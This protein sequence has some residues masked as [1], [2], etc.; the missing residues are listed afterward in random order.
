[1]EAAG[2]TAF[3]QVADQYALGSP[4]GPTLKFDGAPVVAGDR[5]AWAPLGAEKTASGY[6]VAW[7]NAG[8]DQYTVWNTDSAGN[9]LSY[10]GVMSGGSPALENFELSFQQDLNADG[11]IG[12]PPAAP[13][14]ASASG[15]LTLL[16]NSI[17]TTFVPPSGNAVTI[18]PASVDQA[19]LLT[20]PA[21]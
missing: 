15:D 3:Y 18:T 7:K 10:A 4:S 13:A 9:Y 12:P 21:A 1:V 11:T 20:R 16:T 6:E 17:A 14:A 8:A 19:D 2:A 5:G